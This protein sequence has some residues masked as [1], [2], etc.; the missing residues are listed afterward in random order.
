MA[1]TEDALSL[2]TRYLDDPENNHLQ[3]EVAAFRASSEENERFFNEIKQVWTYAE[4]TKPLSG[5]KKKD[6]SKNFRRVLKISAGTGRSM[7]IWTRSI[8]AS[9]F[10]CALGYW[11]WQQTKGPEYLT[12]ITG[13]QIDSVILSDHSVVR[14][15]KE[16]ELRYPI[17][18]IG[19]TR[20]VSLVRGQAFFEI[21]KDKRHPFKVNMGESNVTVLGTSFNINLTDSTIVLGVK[22]GKVQFLPYH[23]AVASILTAGQAISYATQQK[24]LASHSA[25]NQDAWISG[26]LIFVDTPLEE[27]CQQLGAY[28]GVEIV[29]HHK[30]RTQKKLNARFKN[31]P[32]DDVLEVLNETYNLKI[33]KDHDQINLLIY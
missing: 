13:D 5:R 1:R 27:V 21:T 14:I 17:R 23:D 8:A 25:Q 26:E 30:Q 9:L 10:I 31:Q 3:E 33:T 16:S 12:K 28:Y 29:L 4:K 15:A 32:L 2:V 20:E 22:T 18:F 7:A 6:I 24:I 19:S 11:F